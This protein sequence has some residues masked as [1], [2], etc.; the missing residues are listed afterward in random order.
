MPLAEREHDKIAAAL[1]RIR[2]LGKTS[3]AQEAIAVVQAFKG[4]YTLEQ[5]ELVQQGELV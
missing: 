3:R 5:V 2:S 1:E 4:L